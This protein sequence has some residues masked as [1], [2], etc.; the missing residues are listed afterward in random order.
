MKPD[1][2]WGAA[3][4]FYLIFIGGLV[5]FVIAPAMEK[6][7]WK[8]ALLLGALFGL[9]CYATYD[10]TNLALAKDWPLLVTIVD[11]PG[12]VL[13]AS[14]SIATYLIVMKSEAELLWSAGC[15]FFDKGKQKFRDQ[16]PPHF[17]KSSEPNSIRFVQPSMKYLTALGFFLFLQAA[18]LLA[19]SLQL[20]DFNQQRLDR[21]RYSMYVLGA[22]GI[23]NIAG[24]AVGMA[25]TRGS[26]RSFHQMN[27][28][29][30]VVNLGL[31]ASSLL[32]AAHM[33]PA[34]FDLYETAR[35]HHR[36]QK[37][38]LFNAGLDVAY[39]AGG[40]ARW[41]ALKPECK[42]RT[43]CGAS[44]GLSSCRAL[45]FLLLTWA[46]PFTW[47][48]WKTNFLRIL[49]IPL[50]A[51]MGNPWGLRCAFDAEAARICPAGEA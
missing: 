35:Q 14:V 11:L 25:Q 8:H 49:N 19:Q 41:S 40:A 48:A 24:G 47:A 21:T 42:T 5:V 38:L 45:S 43:G 9:V 44:A 39:T 51:S 15:A 6:G 32:T 1:I 29:W 46:P 37:I 23:A 26:Q 2:N 36:M 16:I 18:P 22:W 27:L 10:L 17:F 7:S 34:A 30:G 50:S 28:G 4:I 12:A 13:S 33:D 20:T 31:A 3:I